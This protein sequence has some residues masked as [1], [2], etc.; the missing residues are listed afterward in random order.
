MKKFMITMGVIFI[1]VTVLSNHLFISGDG[2]QIYFAD[3]TG[4]WFEF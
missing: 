1:A 4:Y 2:I 3:G